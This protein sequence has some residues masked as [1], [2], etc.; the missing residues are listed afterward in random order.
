MVANGTNALA[1]SIVLVCRK[2]DR[3]APVSSRREFLA[4]LKRELPNAL[5]RLLTANI[6][7]VDLAQ[8]AIGPGMAIFSAFSKVLE[9][10]GSPMR[11]RTALSLINQSLEEILAEHEGA[12]DAE[13][14]WAITWFEQHGFEEAKY[15]DAETLARAKNTAVAGLVE[16]GIVRSKGGKV[17]LL[18]RDELDPGWTPEADERLTVWETTHYLLSAHEKEGDAGA[19]VLAVRLGEHAEAARDLAYRLYTVCER[20]QWSQAG[21][22]YNSLVVAWS[23][24]L[25]AAAGDV[26]GVLPIAGA[27][28]LGPPMATAKRPAHGQKARKVSGGRSR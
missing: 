10:D 23:D 16:A 7:P 15:G 9:D 2:R 24:I 27:A 26:S 1:S 21:Q 28:P 25:R 17:R 4:T 6:A 11:V 19:G 20:N 18:R 12:Y 3:A 5:R 13:T 8:A 14:R 22:G